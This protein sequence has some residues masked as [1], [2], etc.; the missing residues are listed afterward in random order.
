MTLRHC[1]STVHSGVCVLCV[2]YVCVSNYVVAR[3]K[4]SD[5]LLYGSV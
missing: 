1:A 5:L 2:L 3:L 4:Q